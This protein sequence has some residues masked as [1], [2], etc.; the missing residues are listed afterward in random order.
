MVT[1]HSGDTLIRIRSGKHDKSSPFSHAKDLQELF[2]C[3]LINLK[4]IFL[5]TT[6]GASNA[7]GYCYLFFKE[8]ELDVCC[9]AQMQ[10]D[11]LRS[12]L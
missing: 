11:F 12:S 9:I 1:Y 8:Q 10:P 7:I 6:D 4:I 5:M 2:R 3:K